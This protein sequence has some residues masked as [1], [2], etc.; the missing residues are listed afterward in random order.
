MSS[1]SNTNLFDRWQDGSWGQRYI[2]DP[3]LDGLKTHDN[4][5]A[6]ESWVF[7]TVAHVSRFK[8]DT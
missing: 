8:F 6:F 7:I 1:L 2:V 3:L 4:N 5:L